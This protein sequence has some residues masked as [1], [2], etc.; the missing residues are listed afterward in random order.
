[1]VVNSEVNSYWPQVD[2]AVF[3]KFVNKEFLGSR[4]Y[5]F[6]NTLLGPFWRDSDW[7]GLGWETHEFVFFTSALGDSCY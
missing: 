2:Y 7:I 3:F 1:M 4:G 6:W 5:V